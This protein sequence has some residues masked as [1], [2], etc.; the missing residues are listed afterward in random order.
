[1]LP[2]VY[3]ACNRPRYDSHLLPTT[4][5]QVKHLTGII[6]LRIRE[7]EDNRSLDKLIEMKFMNKNDD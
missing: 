2:S 6:I 5:P 1:M 4:L 3:S 7:R